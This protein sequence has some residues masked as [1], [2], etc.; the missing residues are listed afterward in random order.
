M[1]WEETS[2]GHTG[3]LL[4]GTASGS[5]E[6]IVNRGRG[7]NCSPKSSTDPRMC[8]QL[9]PLCQHSEN[10]PARKHLS[11]GAL[12]D[13]SSPP[14]QSSLCIMPWLMSSFPAHIQH[15]PSHPTPPGSPP[16][17]SHC[18]PPLGS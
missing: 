10:P 9:C 8:A 4:V 18:N 15:L 7:T 6:G 2:S 11:D 3:K 14:G 16:T 12:P 13:P 5:Q 1:G 17:P